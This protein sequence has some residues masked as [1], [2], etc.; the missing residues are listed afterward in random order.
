MQAFNGVPPFKINAFLFADMEMI[1]VKRKGEEMNHNQVSS[2][3]IY[4]GSTTSFSSDEEQDGDFS[5]NNEYDWQR[6]K[7][8]KI[9]FFDDGTMSYFW[10][11]AP[12]VPPSVPACLVILSFY[13]S[14]LEMAFKHAFVLLAGELIPLL[15]F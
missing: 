14:F 9:Q 11:V 13:R 5:Y 3:P 12:T 6:E 15:F 1:E 4:E 7:Q 8:R 2:E 10:Y